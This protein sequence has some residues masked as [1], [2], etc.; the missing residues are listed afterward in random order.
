MTERR[1]S[2]LLTTLGVA[3]LVGA[4][5]SGRGLDCFLVFTGILLVTAGLLGDLSRKDR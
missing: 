5:Y 1:T 3:S 4:V 2:A